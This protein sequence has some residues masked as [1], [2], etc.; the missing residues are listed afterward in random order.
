M[1]TAHNGEIPNEAL[2]KEN[3]HECCV[4]CNYVNMEPEQLAVVVVSALFCTKTRKKGN[5]RGSIG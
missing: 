1:C 2:K 4:S 5:K 3:E